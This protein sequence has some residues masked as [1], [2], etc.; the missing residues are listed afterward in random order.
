MF[1][2]WSTDVEKTWPNNPP[3]EILWR[4]YDVL[5]LRDIYWLTRYEHEEP[6]SW[7]GIQQ[8]REVA[9]MSLEL[10]LG[11]ITSPLLA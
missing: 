8:E 10:L 3:I 7:G 6:W 4:D 11:V 9:W 2:I 5:V 1:R